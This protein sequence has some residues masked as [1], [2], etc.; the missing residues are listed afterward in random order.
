MT[1]FRTTSVAFLSLVVAACGGGAPDTSTAT[2]AGEL[3]RQI[4]AKPA[5]G[6]ALIA[7]EGWTVAEYE[8]LLY[9]VAADPAASAAYEAAYR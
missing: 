4:R 5:E 9:E 1:K 3:A 7:A 8:A 6:P 2:R